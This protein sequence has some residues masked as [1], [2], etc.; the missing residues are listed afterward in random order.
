[1]VLSQILLKLAPFGTDPK[2]LPAVLRDI[3]AFIAHMLMVFPWLRSL[4]S[5]VSWV[6]VTTTQ[7]STRHPD[8]RQTACRLT[9][10]NLPFNG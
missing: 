5:L 7:S 2:Y 4:T 9:P 8:R 3:P 1:M 10:K 6:L